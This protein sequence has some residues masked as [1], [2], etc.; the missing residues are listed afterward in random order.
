MSTDRHG[1]QNQ[2][3]TASPD[4]KCEKARKLFALGL[5]LS[6]VFTNTAAASSSM[7]LP[8]LTYSWQIT[9][10]FSD[11]MWVKEHTLSIKSAAHQG[12]DL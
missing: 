1:G 9:V 3:L 8:A 7:P 12:Q 4:D 10:K 5:T 2:K 11:W 6:T